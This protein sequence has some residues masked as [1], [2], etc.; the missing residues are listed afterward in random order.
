MN[1]EPEQ[2]NG[3]VVD[4]GKLEAL[5]VVSSIVDELLTTVVASKLTFSKS[6]STVIVYPLFCHFFSW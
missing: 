2:E 5:E 3:E 1:Q 4:A 6:V